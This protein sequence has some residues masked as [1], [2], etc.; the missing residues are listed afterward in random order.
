M[1]QEITQSLGRQDTAS[2]QLSRPS[3]SF[4]S[5]KLQQIVQ[6][7]AKLGIRRQAKLEMADYLVLAEDLERFELQDIRCGLDDIGVKPRREG[8]TAFPGSGV[9]RQAVLERKLLRE[10]E[11]L[12]RYE[13]AMDEYRKKNPEHFMSFH[14]LIEEYRQERGIRPSLKSVPEPEEAA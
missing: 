12:R 1:A 13:R 11:E 14:Q 8:E 10:G 2:T 9:L 5:G 4:A 7:L 3:S 6:M